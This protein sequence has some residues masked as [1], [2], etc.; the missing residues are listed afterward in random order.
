MEWLR[1]LPVSTTVGDSYRLVRRIGEGAQGAVYEARHV[2]QDRR[3]AVKIID[4]S[5]T[6]GTEALASFQSRAETASRFSHPHL[7]RVIDFGTTSV[8]QPY[9]VMEYLEG[10]DLGQRLRRLGR[11]Q[12]PMVSHVIRQIALALSAL[13]EQGLAHLALKPTNV[14]LPSGEAD[15]NFVKLLDFGTAQ[16]E[17]AR[18]LGHASMLED[19]LPY[20]AP[21]RPAGAPTGWAN[22]AISGHWHASPGTCWSAGRRSPV[23]MRRRCFTRLPTRIPR[24]S[25]MPRRPRRSWRS[26]VV[27][28]HGG[29]RIASRTS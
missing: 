27:A 23:R 29:K 3:C 7:V 17:N 22:A 11:S 2:Q 14:F 16:V 8:G 18:S 1:E 12:P 6:D 20:V 13:H 19:T 15:P 9:L 5:D 28:S 4:G 10:E 24:R 25:P 26:C 21:N